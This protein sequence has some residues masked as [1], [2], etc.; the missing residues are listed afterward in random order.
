[1][2]VIADETYQDFP[3]KSYGPRFLDRTW[4][5][6]TFPDSWISSDDFAF[7]TRTNNFVTAYHFKYEK[8]AMLFSLKW[9]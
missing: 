5:N 8:D 3:Y 9:S 1:M 6:E 2:S 7:D 4:L